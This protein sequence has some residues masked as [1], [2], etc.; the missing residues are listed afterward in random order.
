M[1]AYDIILERI[2]ADRKR[3]AAGQFSLFDALLGEAE[4]K[5]ILPEIPELP[6]MQKLFAEREVLGVYITGHPLDEY[7]DMFKEVTFDTS[8]LAQ[9]TEPEGEEEAQQL[10][11][12]NDKPVRMAGMLGEVRKVITKAGREM[13]VARLEDLYGTIELIFFSKSYSKCRE[14]LVDDNVVFVSG[15]LS[16]REDEPPKLIVDSI[17]CHERAEAAERAAK[18]GGKLYLKLSASQ[19]DDVNEILCGYPGSSKVIA[20]IDGEVMQF[21]NIGVDYCPALHL[22]LASIL[23]EENVVYKE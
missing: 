4:P 10:F 18:N 22:E 3:T 9:L 14:Y 15:K 19:I 23:G 5:D 1:E 17:I 20:K 8:M 21:E 2:A 12:Y 13:A 11:E 7:R 6:T 16:I